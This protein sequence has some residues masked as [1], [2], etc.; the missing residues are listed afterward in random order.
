[1]F[2]GPE[3]FERLYSAVGGLPIVLD[4]DDATY[5]PYTSPSFGRVSRLFKFFGKTDRLIDRA[6]VV[7]CGNRFI[8]E[9]VEQR[10]TRAVVVPTVVDTNIF[11]PVERQND[12][13]VI[14]WIGTHST[15]PSL[16]WLFPVFERLARR[17]RFA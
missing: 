14:G 11:A 8:A 7:T 13:P 2:F 3:L 1:M 16:E 17:H 5:V 12:P 10:G 15:Y 9:Y 4:L 6:A